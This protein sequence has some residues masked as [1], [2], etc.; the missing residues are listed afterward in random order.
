MA[1]RHQQEPD[2][3]PVTTMI[4]LVL[5]FNLH[6][7]T[8][9]EWI[10]ALSETKRRQRRAMLSLRVELS[11]MKEGTLGQSLSKWRMLQ[12]QEPARI[13]PLNVR[14]WS[15]STYHW[16]G[17]EVLLSCPHHQTM[18]TYQQHLFLFGRRPPS[19]MCT[20]LTSI[21]VSRKTPPWSKPMAPRVLED[22][23]RKHSLTLFVC[24]SLY[25]W[26]HLSPRK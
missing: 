7:L 1:R 9:L 2:F 5:V 17:A 3:E 4:L 14:S 26:F 21:Y 19:I 25:P 8:T 16:M 22:S 15:T 6:A 24:V 23:T 10:V 20:W 11:S 18:P 12:H 13:L